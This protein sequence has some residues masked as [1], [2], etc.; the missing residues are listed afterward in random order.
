M[1]F[2]FLSAIK[3]FLFLYDCIAHDFRFVFFQTF[4]N[5]RRNSVKPK[6]ELLKILIENLILQKVKYLNLKLP[7]FYMKF[8]NI[9]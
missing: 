6:N 8:L 1:S 7:S 4:K 9:K 3:F 2:F 5:K